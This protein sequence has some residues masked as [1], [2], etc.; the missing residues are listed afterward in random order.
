MET[1]SDRMKRILF[2][3]HWNKIE[4][5]TEQAKEELKKLL[6]PQFE[7]IDK[8]WNA[9]GPLSQISTATGQVYKTKTIDEY[10]AKIRAHENEL[11][12]LV[13]KMKAELVTETRILAGT[14]VPEYKPY[15]DEEFKNELSTSQTR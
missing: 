11:A 2:L 12:K 1:P 3:K 15:T 13:E 8:M 6:A 10:Y 7:D 4:I 14:T 9:E 5:K